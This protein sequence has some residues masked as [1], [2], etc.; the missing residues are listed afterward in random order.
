M[1]DKKQNKAIGVMLKEIYGSL[2]V[3]GEPAR[4]RLLYVRVDVPVCGVS[5]GLLCS[6]YTS[7]RL[8]PAESSYPTL[9]M[10]AEQDAS[11]LSGP[12]DAPEVQAI[13]PLHGPSMGTP[14]GAQALKRPKVLKSCLSTSRE[15]FLFP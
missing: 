9:R 11:P 6:S 15:S 8:A 3:R 1:I 7:L 13:C 12:A 2:D 10:Q 14:H 5:Q 4:P